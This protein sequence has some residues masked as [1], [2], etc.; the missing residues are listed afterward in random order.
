MGGRRG[1]CVSAQVDGIVIEGISSG[2]ANDPAYAAIRDALAA[3]IPVV[4]VPRILF[5]GN[6][7]RGTQYAYPGSIQTLIRD[8][9]I[10]GGFLSGLKARILLMVAL[11]TTRDR[12]QLQSIFS[13]A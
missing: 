11:A 2:H 12:D 1:A 9:V 7:V 4:T 5:G 13:C 10:A 6:N 3:G 8:G